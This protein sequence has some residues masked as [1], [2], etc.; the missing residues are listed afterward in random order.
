MFYW[1]NFG[2]LSGPSPP[3]GF[4]ATK[5]L[6]MLSGSLQETIRAVHL[7]VPLVRILKDSGLFRDFPPIEP[8]KEAYDSRGAP[9]SKPPYLKP[10]KLQV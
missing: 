3:T 9:V 10:K 6:R 4:I 7:G 1:C 5:S 2:S 8:N